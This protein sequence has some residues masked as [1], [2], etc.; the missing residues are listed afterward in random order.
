MKQSNRFTA[1]T[2]NSLCLENPSCLHTTLASLADHMLS[3]TVP[4]ASLKHISTRPEWLVLPTNRIFPR[5]QIAGRRG[6]IHR[7]LPWHKYVHS[8]NELGNNDMLGCSCAYSYTRHKLDDKCLCLSYMCSV[9]FLPV[10]SL[11]TCSKALLLALWTLS[12][13]NNSSSDS[14]AFLHF[15]EFSSSPTTVHCPLHVLWYCT[16]GIP[17]W[18]ARKRQSQTSKV[19][20]KKHNTVCS[21]HLITHYHYV[22]VT[23]RY[24][25]TLHVKKMA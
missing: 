10:Q 20:R 12:L 9:L 6:T 7:N 24:M 13:T 2:I 25:E 3:Q 17:F 19:R 23:E 21:S 16:V 5:W 11:L 22:R 4:Q 8:Q 15:M 14:K 1:W 18:T